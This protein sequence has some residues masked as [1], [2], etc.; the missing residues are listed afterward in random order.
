MIPCSL[1]SLETKHQVADWQHE[2]AQSIQSSSRLLSMLGLTEHEVPLAAETDFA[3]RVTR[4]YLSLIEPGNPRDPLLRQ[5]LPLS[6]EMTQMPGYSNDPVGDLAAQLGNGILQKYQGRALLMTTGACA[7]HCRYCFRRHYPYAS[8]LVTPGRLTE[9]LQSLAEMTDL[10]EVILSGGDP[11]SLSDKR[12]Y[13]LID[14]LTSIKGLKRLRIHTRLP[15]A[16][17][18]RVTDTLVDMLA[19]TPL[20]TSLVLHVNHPRELSEPLVKALKPLHNSPV[21]LFNQSVL[22]KGVNDESEILCSLSEQLYDLGVLPYYLHQLDPVQ[23]AAHFQV[24]DDEARSLVESMR[25]SLPGYLV[26]K[27]VREVAQKPSKTPL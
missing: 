27:L 23:G 7:I 17:P 8:D 9:A 13:D 10:N 16:L 5:V 11:L 3:C 20:R 21:T 18:N 6:D 15:V 19:Q 4:H 25:H 26:P 22:L 24:D 12:L 14:A 2:L 1:P